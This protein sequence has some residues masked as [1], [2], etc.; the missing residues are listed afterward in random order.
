MEKQQLKN[1]VMRQI[2]VMCDEFLSIA[3]TVYK[4]PETGYREFKTTEFL[5]NELE[6]SG[7]P[8]ERGIAY[9]GCR[10]RIDAGKEGPVIALMGE[11]D[12]II[13]RDHPDCNLDTGAIHACGHNV[14]TAVAVG[15]AKALISANAMSELSGRLDVMAVPAE[16]CIELDYRDKLIAQGKIRYYSGKPE[17][18]ARGV[19]DDVDMCM[20]IHSL[21]VES[22]GHKV[23]AAC[24]TNGFINKRTHFIGREAH[25]GGSPW[26]G[27]NALNMASIALNNIAYHRETFKDADRVRIHQI[28][29]KGGEI[30][31]TVP[32]SVYMDTMIRAINRNAM[33]DAC[34]KFER[35]VQAAAIALGGHAEIQT[36]P[37][38][39]G[40]ITD[41]NLAELFSNNARL[42][43]SETEIGEFFEAAFS[44]DM[45]DL[46]QIMPI[47][48]AFTGGFKGALHSRYFHLADKDVAIINPIKIMACTVIDLMYGDA[49]EA[50]RIKTESVP[51]MTKDEYL[52]FLQE[53]ESKTSF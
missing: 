33:Q 49:A 35:S 37:G 5:S 46:S 13:C 15:T 8:V 44:T 52:H 1:K 34:L 31:N 28:I 24:R 48:H 29:S 10:G 38:Q 11:M 23:T 6:K 27:V 40:V 14:Q 20:M 25:A 12:S 19:M 7:V 17:L 16:E 47:L 39:M 26:D 42:L 51:F 22:D 32:S 2:D 30:L 3:D 41:M 4:N 53:C 9:T 18:I 21:P 50:K 43:Y 45:G 36:A